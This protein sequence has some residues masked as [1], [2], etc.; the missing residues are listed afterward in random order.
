MSPKLS[1]DEQWSLFQQDFSSENLTGLT[2]KNCQN[3]ISRLF[4]KLSSLKRNKKT[5]MLNN[6]LKSD[7]KIIEST[8]Q[9]S[10]NNV[11]TENEMKLQLQ[12]SELKNNNKGLKR[13]LKSVEKEMKEASV[14]EKKYI[15]AL[16]DFRKLETE[17][18]EL[19]N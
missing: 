1:P 8:Q 11:E 16:E 3:K 5:E 19:V 15:I 7:F 17:S 10:F 14:I 2:K 9:Q 13:K 18:V 4:S 6:L 12:Y